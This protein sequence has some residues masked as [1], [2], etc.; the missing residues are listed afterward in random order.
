ME[1]SA[2]RGAAR[3]GVLASR[4][5][6]AH[7]DES[8]SRLEPYSAITFEVGKARAAF[9]VAN[10]SVFRIPTTRFHH[11]HGRQGSGHRIIEVDSVHRF[12]L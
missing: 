2:A 4:F 1:A 6:K 11:L 10:P 12:P 5:G 9:R 3:N 7:L 8:A